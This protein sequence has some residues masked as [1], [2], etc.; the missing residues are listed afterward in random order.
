[1]ENGG[2]LISQGENFSGSNASS[3]KFLAKVI[4]SYIEFLALLISILKNPPT[5][6]ILAMF[7]P[8]SVLSQIKYYIVLS[9]PLPH[10]SVAR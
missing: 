9:I 2:T 3:Q 1:M 4:T 8:L 6:A 5:I 10:E 7:L